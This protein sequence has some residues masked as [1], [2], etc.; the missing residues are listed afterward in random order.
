MDVWVETR[1]RLRW[2]CG[3][4]G[5]LHCLAAGALWSAVALMVLGQLALLLTLFLPFQV[6]FM[7]ATRQVSRYLAWLGQLMPFDAL[8]V[9]L[10]LATLAFYGLQLLCGRW[11]ADRL[12]QAATRVLQHGDKLALFK[13]DRQQARDVVRRLASWCVAG[14]LWLVYAALGLWVDAPVFAAVLAMAALHFVLARHLLRRP[15]GRTARWLRWLQ[16]HRARAF[17]VWA[18]S[19]FF[20][21]FLLL[22]VQFLRAGRGDVLTAVLAL[23]LLRQMTVWLSQWALGV[24]SL[25]ALQHR[26]NALFDPQQHYAP[27][28][29]APLNAFLDWLA[30]ERRAEWLPPVLAQV[31]GQPNNG[32]VSC[33]WNDTGFLGLAAFDVLVGDDQAGSHAY[34]VR[35]FAPTLRQHAEHEARLFESRTPPSMA[36]RYLGRTQVGESSVLVFAGLPPRRPGSADL[37]ALRRQVHQACAAQ[38]LDEQLVSA[39]LRSHPTL[40]HRLDALLL[41][42]LRMAASTEAQRVLVDRF[43]VAL[44]AIKH[45]LGGLP[46]V[47][48]NPDVSP[49]FMRVGDDGRPV[50]WQWQRWRADLAHPHVPWSTPPTLALA[51][52][53]S[54]LE[55]AA[56]NG[57]PADALGRLPAA[58]AL[59]DPCADDGVDDC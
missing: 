14:L 42:R 26:V 23:L 45:Q 57:R 30:P 59:G 32:V 25:S 29:A 28:P 9:A 37:P 19:L 49:A 20:V 44:D 38:T 16:A 5:R 33:V 27:P 22:F 55:R 2:L 6:M 43:E 13:D 58:L 15:A 7:L 56:R 52:A 39:Y 35:C 36:P 54:A 12:V 48:E 47:L 46:C 50:L 51:T 41:A 11:A 3:L 10:V 53:L 4:L 8:V 18:N 17:S 31:T 21:G 24:V 1:Q 34:F 40:P